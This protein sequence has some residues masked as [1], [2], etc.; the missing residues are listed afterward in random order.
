M[1]LRV[2]VVAYRSVLAETVGSIL[3]LERELRP[4]W[5]FEI[6]ANVE[7]G[8]NR[9]A[10]DLKEDVLLFI[11][12]D[13]VFE[14]RDAS[15]VIKALKDKPKRGAVSGC[16]VRWKNGAPTHNWHNGQGWLGERECVAK[17]RS[18]SGVHP[19]DK[20]G[21]GFLAVS[22]EALESIEFPYFEYTYDENDNFT[23]ED[24]RF[25]QKLQAAGYEP[26]VH[27]GAQIRHIGPTVWSLN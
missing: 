25:C 24:A 19:V 20:L 18:L 9:I 4:V 3:L 11:D 6:G 12:A 27:F 23:S 1:S 13:M 26:S 21:A 14:P 5:Q 15:W 17:S 16:Y 2:G 22:K 10:R 7:N 8:R